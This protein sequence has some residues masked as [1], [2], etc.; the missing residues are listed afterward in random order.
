MAEHIFIPV[1]RYRLV[2]GVVMAV[3]KNAIYPVGTFYRVIFSGKNC[4][5]DIANLKLIPYALSS[6]KNL[7][8]WVL[9][10]GVK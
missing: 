6:V 9:V 8:S 2:N 1:P 3:G 4:T 7:F 5:H 10:I